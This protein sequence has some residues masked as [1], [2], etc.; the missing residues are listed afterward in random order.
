M[1]RSLVAVAVLALSM[2]CKTA[3]PTSTVPV[4][5]PSQD[6]QVTQSL[7]DFGLKFVGKVTGPD[8]AKIEAAVW[9]LVVD[10]KVVGSGT[11]PIGQALSGGAADVA[12]SVTS[13]YVSSADEL[14]AM[15]A[16]GGSLLVALRG[17]FQVRN[18][19]S[20]LEG[21]FAKSREVRTPRLPHMKMQEMEG[22]RFNEAEAGITF[23]LGVYN[24]NPFEISV[25]QISY[26][27]QVAGKSVEKS[28]IGKG[29][30]VNPAS[31]G[32]FDVEVKIEEAT[33]GKD[34]V[35]LIKS[36]VLPYVVTGTLQ[37]DLFSEAFDFKGDLK[38]NE[39]K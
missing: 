30:H 32:V 9:E 33:H 12:F 11:Q 26:E 14:K 3:A 7:T 34:V 8:G 35:K 5:V 20:T 1:M 18:G 25:S 13:K 19:E 37:A 16:R 15:D 24:P 28:V 29:E 27:V 10:G 38:L 36:K 22:A 23:H 31:T 4:E 2:G 6:L 21:Q 17:K 39:S